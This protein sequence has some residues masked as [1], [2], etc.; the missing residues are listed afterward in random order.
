MRKVWRWLLCRIGWHVG[1][2]HDGTFYCMCCSFKAPDYGRMAGKTTDP[3]GVDG[4]PYDR[5]YAA[6]FNKVDPEEGARQGGDPYDP[7]SGRDLPI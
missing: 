4:L 7:D 1:V 6:G 5:P 3:G 2:H